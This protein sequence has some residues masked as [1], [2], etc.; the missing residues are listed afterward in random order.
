MNLEQRRRKLKVGGIWHDSM[1]NKVE[2]KSVRN[3]R[4]QFLILELPDHQPKNIPEG[5]VRIMPMED[6]IESMTIKSFIARATGFD[7]M[8]ETG[9]PRKKNW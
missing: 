5:S 9:R 2:I 6:R 1:D 3:G 7:C 4:V 8:M